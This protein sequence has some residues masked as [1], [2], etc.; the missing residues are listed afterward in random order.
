MISLETLAVSIAL[1]VLIAAYVLLL[2]PE[3]LV[4]LVWLA[5]KLGI[6]KTD[7]GKQA[8]FGGGTGTG[9]GKVYSEFIS[10]ENRRSLHGKIR[11]RGELWDASADFQY[12][13]SLG[14]G[15]DVEVIKKIKTR[16]IVRPLD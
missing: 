14:V 4:P 6:M 1:G 9:R 8:I 10:T 16:L 15:E 12:Q 3:F 11:Y 2:A 5:E 7:Q 13:E